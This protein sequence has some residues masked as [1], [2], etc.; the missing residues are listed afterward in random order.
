MQFKTLFTSS[1]QKRISTLMN[2]RH[3]LTFLRK[4]NAFLGKGYL[5]IIC[6]RLRRH[7]DEPGETEIL[8]S[9]SAFKFRLFYDRDR[10]VK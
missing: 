10:T 2:W 5:Q 4:N 1:G 7:F 9:F 8:I 6:V 3:K